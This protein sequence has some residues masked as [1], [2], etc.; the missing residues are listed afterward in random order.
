MS[1]S[2]FTKCCGATCYPK[3]APRRA[4]SRLRL[5][6]DEHVACMSLSLVR[7]RPVRTV[8]YFF[9]QIFLLHR[10]DHDVIWVHHLRQ[11]DFTDF[12]KQ[13][14]GIQL[15]ETIVRVNPCYQL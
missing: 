4:S 10:S 3:I 1:Q 8:C 15:R 11:M 6:L 14:V 5:G 13:L 2:T 7:G 12:G 9:W